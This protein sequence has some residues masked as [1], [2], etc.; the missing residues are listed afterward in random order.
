VK[1][2]ADGIEIESAPVIRQEITAALPL[3]GAASGALF[4]HAGQAEAR[5]EV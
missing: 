4:L 3:P 5:G 2:S 1:Q